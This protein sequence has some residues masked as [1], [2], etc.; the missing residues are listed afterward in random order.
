MPV[1]SRPVAVLWGVNDFTKARVK[2]EIEFD[3]LFKGGKGLD[4]KDGVG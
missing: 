1:S 3:S 4:T 2:A